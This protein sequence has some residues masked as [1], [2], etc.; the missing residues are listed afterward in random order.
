MSRDEVESVNHSLVLI[1]NLLEAP[2]RPA[3]GPN[4]LMEIDNDEGDSSDVSHVAVHRYYQHVYST[5]ADETNLV[6]ITNL[7][8][9][10]IDR[11]IIHLLEHAN[12]AS[13]YF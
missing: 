2:E 4:D 3:A 7:F 12:R 10:G 6:L 5:D 13:H 9:T 11:I 8:A 1:R